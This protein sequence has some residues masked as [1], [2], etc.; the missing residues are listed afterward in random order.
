MNKKLVAIVAGCLSFGAVQ[1]MDAMS[2]VQR[3][4]IHPSRELPKGLLERDI[5]AMIEDH[6]FS[7]EANDLNDFRSQFISHLS[8]CSKNG[9]ILDL[10]LLT[11]D[12]RGELVTLRSYFEAKFEESK[13]C[14]WK[15]KAQLMK[16]IFTMLESYKP[17]G[18]IRSYVQPSE[19]D[20]PSA[21]PFNKR[22]WV[23]L[24]GAGALF[25]GYGIY[26]VFFAEEKKNAA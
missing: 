10:S 8:E 18:E 26:K 17:V 1:A 13:D 12:K 14:G 23:L 15:E 3:A 11:L 5:I 25:V 19:N 4:F 20:K 16:D 2:N 9:R 22:R 21:E 6:V 24:G 7:T